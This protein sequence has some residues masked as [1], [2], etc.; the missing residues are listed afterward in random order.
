MD[1]GSDKM[2]GIVG[3]VHFEQDL[4]NFP[5][6][7]K[8]MTATLIHRGPDAGAIYCS[9][10]VLLGHRRL[11]II[12][13][14]GGG[15]P[16]TKQGLTIVYNG[17]L[18]NTEAV[19]DLLRQEGHQ[20]STG[21]DTEVILTAFIQWRE[22][23]VN[24]F[25]GIFAFAIWDENKQSL[26][27]SRDHI[28]IKPLFYKE[29][30][31]GLLFSSEIKGLL[32]HPNVKAQ[33]DYRGLS[34]LFSLGPSRTPGDGI[35]KGIHELKPGHA[36]LVTKSGTKTWRY[37]DIQSKVHVHSLAETINQVRALVTDAIQRQLVSDV[38]LCTMLSGG[39]DSS[40]I[41]AVAAKEYAKSDKT[42]STFSVNYEGNDQ[43]FK[44]NAFQVSQDGYWI[45]EMQKSFQTKHQEIVLKQDQLVQSL[46]DVLL[47]KDMP[48]MADI[49]GSL[50]LF[51]KEIGRDFI[52]TLSGEC[53]DEVFGGYP[54]FHQQ[55]E[56]R[57]FPWLRSTEERHQLLKPLWQGRLKLAEYMENSYEESLKEMPHFV[58]NVNEVKRQ[59]LFYLNNMY[60][61]QTLIERS[62][63]M[64]MGASIEVRVPFADYTVM[65]YVW[66][67]PW[68]MKIA[69]G[70]EKGILRRAFEDLLPK[71]VIYRKK[72]PYPKTYHPAYTAGVQQELR[73]ILSLKHSILHELFHKEKLQALL[74]SG[75]D[76]FT[77]PWF[78]QLMA[79]PQL[80]AYLIQVHYWFEHYQIEIVPS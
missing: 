67:I 19:R 36:M 62:D 66:N 76:S 70:M 47:M 26:F 9:E 25:N 68:E 61:M 51:C 39:L 16:M 22:R 2:C 4:N 21:S 35:F 53:A 50:Y 71:D 55:E 54:W 64:S 42:L 56:Q 43:H 77:T 60:F 72:N 63:R 13:I 40:I 49:D 30:P 57:H 3:W 78:G 37:W 10:H 48:S 75:G 79:G 31:E 28:G 14:D 29:M 59:Q 27:L 8:K 12:D 5:D 18:Y 33:I 74:E 80:I 52:V 46:K 6:V 38:P 15:Q 11:S 45:G 20:F 41:T 44:G 58:G 73:T 69:G 1:G 32:S 65:E 24:Y 34:A 23:C 7:I 17:E